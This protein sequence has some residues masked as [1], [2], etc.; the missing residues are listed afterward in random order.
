LFGR[1]LGERSPAPS[2]RELYEFQG[3]KYR[4]SVREVAAL[5][6]VGAFR[7]VRAA[8]VLEGVYRGDES[9]LE[10]DLRHL[11]DKNLITVSRFRGRPKQRFVNLT[12]EAK[13]LTNH[14]LKQAPDQRI[15][16]GIAKLQELDHDAALYRMYLKASGRIHDEGGKPVRIILDYEIKKNLN[17]ELES[18]KKLPKDEESARLRELASEHDLKV[19]DG[20]IPI[21]DVR[22]E[23]ETRDGERAHMDLEYVTGNYRSD[24][25][26]EKARAGFS[27]YAPAGFDRSSGGS[28]GRRVR[29]D[30]P[31]LA[32]E[33]ISL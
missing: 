3:R 13:H 6:A 27:L 24:A 32:A 5:R 23:Y 17:R 10:R 18:A 8:D 16:S 12:P 20:K 29:D 7:T 33:I 22:I 25:I 4:L 9:A 31:S 19:V 26:A 28:A 15:Y 30:Y 1:A 14:H 2:E 21:P 11:Q